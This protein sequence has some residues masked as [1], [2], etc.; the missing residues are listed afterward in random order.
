[1]IKLSL[2][3]DLRFAN[4]KLVNRK[5]KL[6]P[7]GGDAIFDGTFSIMPA[8]AS[9]QAAITAEATVPSEGGVVAADVLITAKLTANVIKTVHFKKG[10][11][12][13][14]TGIVL[15]EG[16]YS[17]EDSSVILFAPVDT[18][19]YELIALKHSECEPGDGSKKEVRTLQIKRLSGTTEAETAEVEESLE[20]TFKET[21]SGFALFIVEVFDCIYKTTNGYFSFFCIQFI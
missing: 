8:G 10:Q 12:A 21:F 15:K 5:F 20:Q 19:S 2:N 1:M 13:V 6:G 16:E 7:E 3:P 14:D 18:S 9:T 4:D 11:S 17:A